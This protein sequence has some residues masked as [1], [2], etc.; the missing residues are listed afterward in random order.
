M[1]WADPSEE[2]DF[3]SMGNAV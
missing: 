1:A 2:A 3:S